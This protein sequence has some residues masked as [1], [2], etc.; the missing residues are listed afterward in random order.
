[1]HPVRFIAAVAG[2]ASFFQ[3]T[4]V[5]GPKLIPWENDRPNV[6]A[7]APANRHRARNVGRERFAGLASF[8]TVVVRKRVR[9]DFL[10]RS[11]RDASNQTRRVVHR[12]VVFTLSGW[13]GIRIELRILILWP[14]RWRELVAF[15]AIFCK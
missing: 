10:L 3:N 11:L 13:L 1:I 2:N 4:L 14:Q 6:E 15:L 5:A 8:L 12:I 9:R 7:V